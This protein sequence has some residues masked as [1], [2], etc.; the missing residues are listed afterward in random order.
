M[1]WHGKELIHG[2]QATHRVEKSTAK[3]QRLMFGRLIFLG[4]VTWLPGLLRAPLLT[5]FLSY[6]ARLNSHRYPDLKTEYDS[7]IYKYQT[8][9][10]FAPDFVQSYYFLDWPHVLAK[11]GRR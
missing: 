11:P 2:Q 8:S 4:R 9:M 1:D 6:Q 3:G 5:D 10:E 7:L